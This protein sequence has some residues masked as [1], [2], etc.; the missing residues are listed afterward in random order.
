MK[1]ML[2]L[3]FLILACFTNFAHADLQGAPFSPEVDKRFNAIEQGNHINTLYPHGASDGHNVKQLA[4]A[5]Y[6]FAKQTGAIGTYDLGIGLPAKAIVVRSYAY[7]TTKPTT[8]ASGTLAFQCQDA[9]NLV[10]AT[11]AASYGAAGA[12][13]DGAATGAASAF[14][15]PSAKCNIKAVIATGA[16]TAG[17]VTVYVEYV[18]HQ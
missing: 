6:D 14:Q 11:A 10:A 8:G 12:S 15:Y 13:I 9:G 1:N 2:P 4:Q 16:L 5:T 17:K 3:V 7:S 18:V